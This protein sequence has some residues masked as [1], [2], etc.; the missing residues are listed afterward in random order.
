MI[1]QKNEIAEKLKQLKTIG[2]P[3]TSEKPQGV[4]LKDNCLKA[5]N[6][7]IAL[8]V[9]LS[10]HTDEAFVIPLSAIALIESLPEGEVE[11]KGTAKAVTVKSGNLKSRFP[12]FSVDDYSEPKPMSEELTPAFQL[13]F[14]DVADGI[15]KIMYACPVEAAKPV[16]Q[17]IYFDGNGQHLNLVA[18]DAKRIA[19]SMVSTTQKVN[20]VVPRE[21][22]KTLLA[23]GDTST[24]IK[25]FTE[26]KRVIVEIGEYTIY[27][28]LY[29]DS[30]MNYRAVFPKDPKLT[31]RVNKTELAGVLNRCLICQNKELLKSQTILKYCKG[32][33]KMSV[34]LFGATN[35]FADVVNCN[36]NGDNDMRIGF[37]TRYLYDAVKA[38]NDENIVMQFY[39]DNTA[40]IVCDNTLRQLIAP[41]MLS[42]AAKKV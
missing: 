20:V 9:P 2:S 36:T 17:G 22:I 12:T 13:S 37:N 31:L 30:Y 8:T 42:D 23:V 24:D 19:I 21:A 33:D 14:G 40:F 1:I 27:A 39:S 29:S 7:Q 32:D 41:V 10:V 34:I 35:G 25:F 18:S 16:L 3:K 11:I 28:L 38:S 6:L 5:N 26:D 15:D 4:L